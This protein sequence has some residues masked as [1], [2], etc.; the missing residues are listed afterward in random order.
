MDSD[1]HILLPAALTAETTQR[2]IQGLRRVEQLQKDFD[3]TPLGQRKAEIQRQL[4]AADSLPEAEVQ[5]LQAE[6]REWGPDGTH[7]LRMSIGQ[8][9]GEHPTTV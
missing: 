9:A 2:A 3:Q 4:Q 7:G 1:G 5:A 6:L 8:L